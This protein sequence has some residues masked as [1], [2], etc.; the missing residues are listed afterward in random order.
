MLE[1][2]IANGLRIGNTWFKRRESHLVTYTS[3]GH[4][5]QID[6]TLYPKSLSNTAP[7]EETVQQHHLV[8]CDLTICIPQVKKHK[9]KPRFRLWK[10]RDPAIAS[11]FQEIF[12]EK[13]AAANASPDSANQVEL[14]WANLKGPLLE[15]ATETCG[16]SKNHLWKLVTWWWNDHVSEAVRKKRFCFKAYNRLQKQ[17]MA[18]T[19]DGKEAK[20]AYN[21]AKRLAKHV[22]WLTK[23]DAEK[24]EF[25]DVKPND[26]STF[27]IARQMDCI[28][29]DVVGEPCVCNDAGELSLTDDEKLA[30]WVEH[31]SRL[32]NIKFKWPREEFTEVAPTEG[33]RPSVSSEQIRK[34]LTK[35]KCG[36]AAGPS[37]ITAEM[38]EAAGEEGVEM[39]RELVEAVFKSGVIPAEWEKSIFQCGLSKCIYSPWAICDLANVL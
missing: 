32:L 39:M 1:F 25:S 16:L 22:V 14:I 9:F 24:V 34:A 23:S 27:R 13:V 8:I 10:L 31:Y 6:L 5:I 12:D 29:R 28:N 19:V 17:G 15:A 37:G 26:N 36:K 20:A 3:G 35:I 11:Q 4:S 7:H 30:A 18:N 38:F 21:E 33:P 2:A